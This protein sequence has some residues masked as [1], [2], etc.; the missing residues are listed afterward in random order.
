MT[1][2]MSHTTLVLAAP[3]AG[4]YCLTPQRQIILDKLGE[5]GGH[6]T[7]AELYE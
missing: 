7:V 4:G 2:P 5:R 1:N 6:V 3:H